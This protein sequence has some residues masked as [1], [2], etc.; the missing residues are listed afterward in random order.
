MDR[1]NGLIPWCLQCLMATK[2]KVVPVAVLLGILGVTSD[3][4]ATSGHAVA[5]AV[6]VFLAYF[7]MI[8]IVKSNEYLLKIEG[9]Y[10]VLQLSVILNFT[11]MRSSELKV[12][13]DV[14][15]LVFSRKWKGK[16]K[17]AANKD[18]GARKPE[19]EDP[20]IT[21]EEGRSHAW[22]KT[23]PSSPY[24]RDRHSPVNWPSSPSTSIESPL[25]STPIDFAEGGCV[26]R[27]VGPLSRAGRIEQ[28]FLLQS[29]VS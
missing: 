11:N 22:Q 28:S 8:P 25:I 24:L 15:L 2:V 1:V 6:A 29:L 5:V 10:S 7:K 27:G 9:S 16:G 19:A 26:P 3:S 14:Y 4:A 17:K 23:A 21:M 20:A 18:K 13:M 12:K